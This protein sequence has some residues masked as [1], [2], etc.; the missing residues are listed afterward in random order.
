MKTGFC[1]RNPPQTV[2]SLLDLNAYGRGGL[3][4]GV[5]LGV[6]LSEHE[7]LRAAESIFWNSQRDY[8]V[9]KV[10][11]FCLHQGVQQHGPQH[12]LIGANHV[13]CI[14]DARMNIK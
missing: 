9:G 12:L 11:D 4:T 13:S 10:L 2:H 6:P 14:A 8:P 3:H 5:F 7:L 1:N